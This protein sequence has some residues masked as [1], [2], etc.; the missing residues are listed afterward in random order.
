MKRI[1]RRFLFSSLV[2][3]A[4]TAT[5]QVTD[6]LGSGRSQVN[7]GDTLAARDA[8]L[9][10]ARRK[11]IER[12][13]LEIGGSELLEANLNILND[14]IYPNASTYIVKT[15][16]SSEGQGDGSYRVSI[17]AA[18]DLRALRK[19]LRAAGAAPRGG[20]YRPKVM[21]LVD[22]YF[23]T[24]ST[25][26]DKPTLAREVKVEDTKKHAAGLRTSS[27]SSSEAGAATAEHSASGSSEGKIDA[28]AKQKESEEARAKGEV[29]S[30]SDRASGD[31]G[32][33]RSASSEGH[34]KGQWKEQG[35]E[36]DSASAA[37]AKSAAKSSA[38]AFVKDEEHFALSIK[39]Y[40]PD[41]AQIA[42]PES[43]AA[44]E[45]SSLLLRDDFNLVDKAF[46][47][48][49]REEELGK[50]GYMVNYLRNNSQVALA[51][52][53][54]SQKYGADYLVIG[55]C[56]VVYRGLGE[57]GQQI[58]GA[59][60]VLKVV[61]TSTGQVVA[62][63]TNSEPG[64]SGDVQS[65]RFGAAKRVG[66]TVGEALAAQLLEQGR[67][68]AR[69]GIE[70]DLKLY[71]VPDLP[72]KVAFSSLLEGLDGV[73]SVE[74]RA[75]DRS[76]RRIEYQVTYRGTV[77]QFKNS[78]FKR[79][80]AESRWQGIDEQISTGNNVNLVLTAKK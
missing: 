74:E 69:A 13:V 35:A 53:K 8:A 48:Q 49:L 4:A 26:R 37:Y 46:V 16:V 55:A 31:A 17:R 54:A 15:T 65:S 40:F 30:G 60:L 22:E 61:S 3:L 21:V 80:F 52:R 34:V 9:A 39:E 38:S 24:D 33:S 32:A 72:T 77:T 64:M 66:T 79:L 10:E 57:G 14:E 18:V 20:A 44:A 42:L 71:G 50:T 58:S 70:I 7:G 29:K 75:Y 62:A 36:H 78:L 68:R 23:G 5:A 76:N 47:Q 63:V 56:N 43:A 51:A 28:A 73:Q 45:I 2:L 25:P 59:N 12:A 11:A 1:A 27:E 41:S 67:N 6:F 19:D